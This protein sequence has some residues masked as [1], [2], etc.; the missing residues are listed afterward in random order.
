MGDILKLIEKE[1]GIPSQHLE[2]ELRHA[3]HSYLS[4]DCGNATLAFVSRKGA[5]IS[6]RTS[7]KG[8]IPPSAALE[9]FERIGSNKKVMEFI[10]RELCQH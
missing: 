8:H 2:V 6:V 4:I 1:C 3:I 5:P 9:Y 10:K 7:F